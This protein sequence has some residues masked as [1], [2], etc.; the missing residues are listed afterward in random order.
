MG[1]VK[2]VCQKTEVD[3]YQL[4]NLERKITTSSST[5]RSAERSFRKAESTC[6]AQFT[7][8]GN[9]ENLRKN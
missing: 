4:R 3:F 1:G 8:T 7:A 9:L 2:V 5:Q 6:N